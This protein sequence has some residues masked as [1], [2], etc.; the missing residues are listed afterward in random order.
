MSIAA[1]GAKCN[2]C[3]MGARWMLDEK[4]VEA[5]AD[6]LNES[7]KKGC[8]LCLWL[9]EMLIGVGPESERFMWHWPLLPKCSWSLYT[10]TK[11]GIFRSE[12]H[13]DL[14]TLDGKY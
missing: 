13:F 5:T 6:E 1:D 2:L 4:R 7:A 3:G 9:Q 12:H 10:Q 8:G 14:F 11:E